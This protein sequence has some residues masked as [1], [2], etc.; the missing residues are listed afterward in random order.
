MG[1]YLHN[2]LANDEIIVYE[3]RPS[4]MVLVPRATLI[5]LLGIGFLRVHDFFFGSMMVVFWLCIFYFFPI[6][7][8]RFNIVLG[9]TNKKLV[10]K[11]G[12]MKTEV[13]ASPLDAIVS[14]MVSSGLIGKICDYGNVIISTASNRYVFRA[15]LRPDDFRAVLMGQVDQYKEDLLKR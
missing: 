8:S 3:A 15:I 2:Y 4:Y 14:V 5:L 11:I 12:I 6:L 10:G 9:F 13:M 1:K 7:I